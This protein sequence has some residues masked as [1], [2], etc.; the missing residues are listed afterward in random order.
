MV[1]ENSDKKGKTYLIIVGIV[2]AVIIA[3]FWI[4]GANGIWKGLLLFI[5]GIFL[6][7]ILFLLAYLF[8]FL[9]IKKHKFDVNYVNKQKIIEACN[10]IKRPLLKELY[11]S[12]DKGHSRAKVGKIQGYLRMQVLTRKYLYDE[13]K[14]EQGRSIKKLRTTKNER[15][16]DIA[17]YEVEKFEQDIFTVKSPGVGGL[18]SDPMVIRV[19][20]EDHTDLVGDVT[21]FGFSLIPISEYWFL[22]TDHL[23]VRKIDYAILKEAERTIA[24]VTLT[25]MKDLI[26]SATG[27]DAKHKKIIQS[28]SLVELPETRNVGA[29]ETPYR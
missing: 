6:L 19:N 24:F 25:D 21:L 13:I 3:V 10:K 16:E 14:D 11:V 9:F 26:D 12:G 27:I 7:G 2:L 23:D 22:N 29:P 28:K 20:P 4:F 5:E 1:A 18:F 17:L 8:Y 15:D